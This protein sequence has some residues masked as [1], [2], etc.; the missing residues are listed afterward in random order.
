MLFYDFL[1]TEVFKISSAGSPAKK[2][3]FDFYE[4][5]CV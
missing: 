5:T 4:K 1:E 2:Q 3:L